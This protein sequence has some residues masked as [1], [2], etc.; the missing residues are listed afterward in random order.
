VGS[1]MCIRDSFKQVLDDQEFQDILK[2]FYVR[3]MY[4]RLRSANAEASPTGGP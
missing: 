3:K 1:E 2:D 4:S